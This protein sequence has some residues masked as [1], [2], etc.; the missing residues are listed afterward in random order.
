M[1]PYFVVR[2]NIYD[3]R[4]IVNIG[5][6]AGLVLDFWNV[7]IVSVDGN[8]ELLFEYK[9]IKPANDD[10]IDSLTGKCGLDPAT[11][12]DF[13]EYLLPIIIESIKDFNGGKELPYPNTNL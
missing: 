2:P 12:I 5:P 6:Y 3:L 8:H 1:K 9:I 13:K 4:L 7:S 11:D 10:S